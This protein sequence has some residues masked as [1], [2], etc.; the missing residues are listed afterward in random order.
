MNTGVFEIFYLNESLKFDR[1][2]YFVLFE[3]RLIY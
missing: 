1:V 3:K 2:S